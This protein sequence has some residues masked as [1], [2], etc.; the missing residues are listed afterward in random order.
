MVSFAL[1][2]IDLEPDCIVIYHAYNDIRS[3]LTPGFRA[4]YAHSRRNIGEVY[5]KFYAADAT[6]TFGL[7]AINYLRDKWLAGNI[8]NSLLD[9][10]S[11]GSVDMNLDPS[12]GLKVYRRN[13]QGIIDLAR[14]KNV[15]VVL[16]TYCHFLHSAVKDDP[17][18]MRYETIVALENE[19]MRQLAH[20]NE[21]TLVDNATDF[22]HDELYFVD[23]IHFSPAGMTRLAENMAGRVAPLLPRRP[24]DVI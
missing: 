6:P 21:L 3:Y 2:V 7:A 13:L 10:A 12:P 23:S 14:S 11:R 5:W 17:L 1:Q 22:P 19:I 18:H 24:H 4:D 16:S 15:Q 9:L 8:R 20:Q